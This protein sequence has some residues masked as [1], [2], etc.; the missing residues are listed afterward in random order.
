MTL[1]EKIDLK[2]NEIKHIAE[3]LP[4]VT[5]I[6]R[7]HDASVV[8][9]C[10]KGLKGLGISLEELIKLAPEDYYQRF[11]NEEDAKY[12]NPKVLKLLESN[13]DDETISLFQ[14]VKVDKLDSWTW[15]MTSVR[16]FLRDEENKPLLLITQSMP[17]DT[18]HPLTEKASKIM[19]ENNFLRENFA[20]F[21]QLTKR[22]IEILKH[23]A[24]GE[25][26]IECGQ[27]LYISPQTVETHRK[28][29]RKKL[30]TN[31]FYELSKYARAFDL[32]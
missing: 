23:L 16:I 21:S 29:I 14:Q 17:I 12:Y 25:S 8:W 9:M 18:M 7:I 22:E 6:H 24:K 3:Y 30:K 19:E 31:S 10:N 20:L 5:M 11:F 32:I 26:A 27:Q 15:H 1:E 2:I 13:N 28:N 4:C